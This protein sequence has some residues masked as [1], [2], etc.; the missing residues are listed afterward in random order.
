MNNPR[1]L[2][3][4]AAMATVYIVWGST[5]LGIRV[6][7]EDL[8][9]LFSAGVRFLIAGLLM[10]G[11]AKW[12]GLSLPQRP[13]DWGWLATTGILMLVG[14][15][16]LVTWAEQWVDSSQAA[17]IV[18]TAALW[19]AGIG[20]LGAQGER[21][22]PAALFGLVLGLIGVAVLV[23]QGVHLRQAP[24][25]A[26][27]GMLAAPALWALGSILSKRKHV[28]CPPL[29]SAT[30]QVLIAGATL[31][32]L[33]LLNGEHAEWNWSPRSLAAL[34][35]L[36]VFGT[37]IGYTCYYWLVH[38]VSPS[39]LGTNAYVNPAV[40]VLLGAW[41]LDEHLGPLQITGTLV[42]LGSVIIVTLASRPRRKPA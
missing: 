20:S 9:P 7:V 14:A 24:V 40:A 32:V 36:V 35:Y 41:L 10:L 38:Q 4:A 30:L 11:W 37:C 33:G 34:A 31:T 1:G 23:G 12:K 42:I 25:T 17:L 13:Q 3:V 16:G 27:L 8:P 22:H 19:I 21:V 6:M 2:Q 29:M 26:Y 18:A 5:Y 39:T 15:N 28:N